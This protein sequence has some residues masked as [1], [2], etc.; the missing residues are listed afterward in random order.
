ML[1]IL[2]TNVWMIY[3]LYVYVYHKIYIRIVPCT[4]SATIIYKK[5]VQKR[6]KEK[7]SSKYVLLRIH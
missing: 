5:A 1:H 3:V 6:K 2:Y 7:Q 4:V